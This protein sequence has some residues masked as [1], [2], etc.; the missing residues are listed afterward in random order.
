MR[1]SIALTANSPLTPKPLRETEGPVEGFPLLDENRTGVRVLECKR[2][3]NSHGKCSVGIRLESVVYSQGFSHF[4]R[5]SFCS[6]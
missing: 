3:E 4:T 6:P 2:K 5:K 1:F